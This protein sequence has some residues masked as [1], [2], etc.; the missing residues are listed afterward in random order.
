MNYYFSPHT[1]E[2]IDTNVPADWMGATTLAPPV[3][4]A[5]TQG[6]FFGAGAWAVVDAVPPVKPVPQTVTMR[7]ARLALLAAGKLAAVATAIAALPS[8]QK[9][10]AQIE[11]EYAST[12]DRA[13][14]L[15]SSLA[16][17]LGL[18]DEALDALFLQAAK[19]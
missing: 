11:W 8:P 2:H 7:Q 19:L 14:P 4:D 5:I 15:I 6:A 13:S 1:G 16:T 18:D 9:D 3:F 12:I 17:A 10:A